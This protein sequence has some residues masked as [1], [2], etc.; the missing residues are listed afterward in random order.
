MNTKSP[1]SSSNFNSLHSWIGLITITIYL[2]NLCFALIREGLQRTE[3]MTR[4]YP[5]LMTNLL[6]Y[7]KCLGYFT[8]I[9]TGFAI[10]TGI[11]YQQYSCTVNPSVSYQQLPLGCQISYGVGMTTILSI[12]FIILAIIYRKQNIIIMNISPPSS[13]TNNTD[14]KDIQSS[15]K[16]RLSQYNNNH[17]D[18]DREFKNDAASSSQSHLQNSYSYDNNDEEW[19]CLTDTNRSIRN[20]EDAIT[21]QNFKRFEDS[22]EIGLIPY[23]GN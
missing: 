22:D 4:H 16:K 11:S 14:K 8:L 12:I 18:D 5:S 3:W 17:N 21:Q 23:V 15:Y 6:P 7:H 9:F 13:N 10:V 2:L 19:K 1:N 20:I